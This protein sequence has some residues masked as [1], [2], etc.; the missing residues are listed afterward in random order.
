[1][2]NSDWI[3][4][5][6]NY[7]QRVPLG[8]SRYLLV[9]ELDDLPADNPLHDHVSNTGY[10]NGS[11]FQDLITELGTPTMCLFSGDGKSAYSLDSD[12]LESVSV[13]TAIRGISE[14]GGFY[15]PRGLIE[16]SG[17]KGDELRAHIRDM[18][19]TEFGEL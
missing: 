11:F 13:D 2:T 8:G 5:I 9:L 12:G 17:L 18:K 3:E 15:I 10:T 4:N 1:M 7:G 14:M 16:N 19:T 6:R